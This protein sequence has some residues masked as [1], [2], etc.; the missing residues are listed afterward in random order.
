MPGDEWQ[1]N[2]NLRLLFGY[3]Y[4]HPG[5]KLLFMGCEIAQ[6]KE[7]S[8]EESIE[9]DSLQ[10]PSHADVQRWVKDLNRLYRSEPALYEQDFSNDGFEW[11]DIHDWEN[12]CI[13]FLR[14]GKSPENTIL[15]VCNFTPVPRYNYHLGVPSAGFWKEIL[16]SDAQIYGGSGHGNFGGVE[17]S[18]MPSHGK[19]CSVSITLP[20]LGVLFFKIETSGG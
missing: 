15:V 20:P 16:N 2:A 1:K 14:K 18:P 9:W 13:S 11:I 19:S 8:H 12:S 4:G 6:W 10:Y 5:K 7:W 17:A 3:M